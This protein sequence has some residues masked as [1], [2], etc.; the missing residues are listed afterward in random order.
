MCTWI[1]VFL[2]F[3][4]E[5]IAITSHKVI[6]EFINLN[7]YIVHGALVIFRMLV[8]FCEQTEGRKL[9]EDLPVQ[10]MLETLTNR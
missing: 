8:A 2:S 5:L 7:S 1:N 4:C 9:P 3:V 6:F 10:A